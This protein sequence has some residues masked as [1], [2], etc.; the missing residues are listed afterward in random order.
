M[1]NAIKN[2]PCCPRHCDLAEPG[3]GHGRA[4][5]EH[6]AQGG[7]P[8]DFKAEHG[9]EP[10]EHHSEHEHHHGPRGEHGHHHGPHHGPRH[11]EGDPESLSGLMHR[12]GHVLHHGDRKRTQHTVLRMLAEQGEMSQKDLQERLEIRP[13]SVSEL[14]AKLEHKGLVTK[15]RDEEDKRRATLALTDAGR[16]TAEKAPEPGKDLFSGL[17]GEEQETL[18]SLLKKLLE[19]WK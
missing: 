1:E 18:R 6:L 13:G 9:H 14:V 10:H 16:E 11:F 15:T 5:A 8:E 17:S 12:C 19:S 3:C 2:C 4:F 7:K